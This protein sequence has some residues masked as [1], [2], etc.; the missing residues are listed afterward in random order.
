MED[1]G[2]VDAACAAQSLGASPKAPSCA[3]PG[4][5]MKRSRWDLRLVACER[6]AAVLAAAWESSLGFAGA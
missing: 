6:D 4:V 3:D 5:V 2:C 1:L